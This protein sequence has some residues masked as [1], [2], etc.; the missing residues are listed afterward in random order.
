MDIRTVEQ[1]QQAKADA[2]QAKKGGESGLGQ[3]DFLRLMMEQMKAQ[4]PFNPMDN[5]QFISQMAQLTSVSSISEMNN[6]FSSYLGS[7]NQTQFVNASNLVGREVLSSADFGVLSGNKGISGQ[8]ELPNSTQALDIEI[9]APTG[10]VMG[11][12]SM[13]PQG[14][15]QVPFEWD[16]KGLDGDQLPPGKYYL[17]ANYLNG[18]SVEQLSTQV[19]FEVRSVSLPTAGGGVQLEL[20]GGGTVKLSDLV[21]VS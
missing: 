9:L 1:Y 7:L 21:S 18:G 13:G 20:N 8:V 12:V 16:G 2:A 10:E 11:R 17:R 14:A 6:N 4:D 5:T 19:N 3:D 15:G